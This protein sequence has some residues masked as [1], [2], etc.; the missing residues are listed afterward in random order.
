MKIEEIKEEFGEKFT[1]LNDLNQYK[2]GYR[3]RNG[4]DCMFGPQRVWN[5]IESTIS[6]TRQEVLEEIKIGIKNKHRVSMSRYDMDQMDGYDF[7]IDDVSKLLEDL[8][9]K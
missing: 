5:F 2:V 4:D 7:A 9:K 3:N 8:N 1:F 6:Q